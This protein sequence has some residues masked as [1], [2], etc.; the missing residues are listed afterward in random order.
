MLIIGVA[1]S[2]SA[3][4]STINLAGRESSGF[5]ALDHVLQKPL[6]NDTFPAEDKGFGKH[7]FIGAGGG[8]SMLGD[9][10]SGSVKP[11]FRL[12]GQI[13]GWL[14]PVHGLRLGADVGFMSVHKGIDRTWLGAL[15]AEYL[16]N[17]SSLL[18]GYD[19]SRRFELIGAVGLEYQRLRQHGVW[20]NNIG[21]EAA[22]QMRFNV[23]PSLFLFVEPRLAMMTGY[24]Y[25]GANDWRRMKADMSLNIGLGYR[26]LH[27][28]YRMAGATRFI[29]RNDDNL[30]FGVGAGVWDMPRTGFKMNNPT[31]MA[32]A[33]K[34][35]SSTSGL[36]LT[37]DF[38]QFKAEAG[39]RNKY[40]G[41]GSLDYVLNLDNAFG[42]YRP[43]QTFQ[44]LLN[45][46]VGAGMVTRSS[47]TRQI[48]PALSAGLTGL[49]RLSSN[50]GIF[51]HPQI[52]MFNSQTT[53]ALCS[54]CNSKAPLAS[55][56]VGVRYTIGDFSRLLPESYTEYASAKHWFI[57]SGL[58]YAHRLRGDFGHGFDAYLGFGK[59]FTPISS[60]RVTLTGD[61]FPKA[62]QAIAVIAHADYLSS[63]TTAMYGYDPERLFDLQ[64]VLGAFGGIAEYD[65]PMTGTFGLTGG[66]QANFRL[67]SHLDLYVEPQ[68]LA[69]HAPGGAHSWIPEVRAQLGLRYRLGT[70]AGGR[71]HISETPYGDGRN[72]VSITGAPSVFS[73]SF[74]TKDMNMTGALDV[75]LGR[76]FS[77]VSGLRV[78]YANNWINHAGK[79]HY[80]GSAHLDY[81]L[82]V[83]SLLDRSA[84]RR[85]HILGAVGAGLAISPDA[86]SKTGIM[87]YGGIQFRYNLPWNIDVHIEPG[88]EFWANRVVPQPGTRHRFVMNGRFAVGA[89]YRF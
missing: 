24:K 60:W 67:N 10:F 63:I 61:V 7:I 5:N 17:M 79:I 6:G 64:M 72:F 58:G 36:Q 30:F 77:M 9:N 54:Y 83:T 1:T 37:M 47:E 87:T 21:L 74:S 12:G 62:P 59:R 26:I 88:A 15:R 49:F 20:G 76:W 86:L 4:R 46:G 38:G 33:G 28:K 44:M 27:G 68:F 51:I 50:W 19:P 32:Y 16:L 53:R 75:A 11:G 69:I 8:F 70:P 80:V 55:V 73:G 89:S 13:G 3:K 56:N 2:A 29:Q 14:T 84:S 45:V 18:R 71:G 40:V 43:N 85:F 78:V 82:N 35:F 52:Y 39:G 31:A 57:T 22:L 66:L 41:I 65:G 42:G 23:A 34:M 48:S 81:L 25:D